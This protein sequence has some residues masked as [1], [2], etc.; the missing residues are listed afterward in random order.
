MAPL[1]LT[2]MGGHH[3]GAQDVQAD[4][5]L[6]AGK[7][8]FRFPVA[9]VGGSTVVHGLFEV[10]QDLMAQVAQ[11]VESLLPFGRGFF[12]VCSHIF[13]FTLH[14]ISIPL[15]IPNRNREG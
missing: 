10:E 3:I 11:P 6:L 1:L 13:G 7:P 8:D 14:R 15:P 2:P 5:M 4:E 12:Y 9:F